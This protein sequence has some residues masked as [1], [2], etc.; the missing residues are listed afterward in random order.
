MICSPY[1][2]H[3]AL[4][5]SRYSRVPWLR[6]RRAPSTGASYNTSASPQRFPP[7]SRPVVLDVIALPFSCCRPSQVVFLLS[8]RCRGVP[9]SLRVT[10]PQIQAH[11]SGFLRWSRG[12]RPRAT[13]GSLHT[14]VILKTLSAGGVSGSLPI[15]GHTQAQGGPSS[16]SPLLFSSNWSDT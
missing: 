12:S 13:R 6:T 5:Q 8:S 11:L 7:V 10:V 1:R 15:G 4:R 9:C 14:S 3:G 2:L 16:L